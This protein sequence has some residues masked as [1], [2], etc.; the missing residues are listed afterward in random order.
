MDI[1]MIFPYL[2][3]VGG[4]QIYFMECLKRWQKNNDITI[5][6]MK[7]EEELYHD[8]NIDCDVTILNPPIVKSKLMNLPL[9]IQRNKISKQIPKH[10]I[11]NSH[12][13]PF[14]SLNL[15]NNI[16]TPQEPPRILYDLNI[17]IKRST[18]PNKIVYSITAPTLRKINQNNYNTS[19]TIANSQY[20]KKYLEKVYNID[21]N[22]V[23]YPGVDYKK[24]NKYNNEKDFK[25][26]LVVSRLY[27]E[28]RVDI[29][30]KALTYLDTSYKLYIVGKGPYK[31][32]LIKLAKE[33]NLNQQV[34]FLDFVEDNELIN[35]YKTSLCTVFMPYK[36]PFG[37]VVLESMAASTPIIGCNNCGGY[38][39]LIK[40]GENGFLIE[41]NPKEIAK[42]IK[43]LNENQDIYEQMVKNCKKTAEKYTWKETADNTMKVFED[44]LSNN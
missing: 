14:H 27:Y 2:D 43:Y 13:F 41:Y 28:K 35:A 31:E 6:T 25:K 42:K 16:W 11:Y 3:T 19:E 38:T 26:I 33:L 17:L 29:A 10:E 5:Y 24:Y 40:N 34:I 32:D 4:A 1:G 22:S 21:I 7:Y 30:I 8:Y 9:L 12:L 37:M 15:K 20:S 23:V 18:I 44:Y 36:E 39:E